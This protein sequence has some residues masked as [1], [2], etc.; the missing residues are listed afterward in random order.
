MSVEVFYRPSLPVSETKLVRAHF[1]E[2]FVG[3]PDF[4]GGG[5]VTRERERGS[6]NV[7]EGGVGS[8]LSLPEKLRSYIFWD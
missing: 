3:N 5:Q 1:L 4:G 2:N 7:G 8:G 6:E